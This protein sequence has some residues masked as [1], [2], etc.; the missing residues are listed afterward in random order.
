MAEDGL[1]FMNLMILLG[2][3]S[4]R[5]LEEIARAPDRRNELLYKS[6]EYIDMLAG[7]K[8]RTSGRLTDEEARVMDTLLKDLQTRYVKALASR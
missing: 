7:L 4:T 6:R 3:M 5:R 1:A 8:K 2:S